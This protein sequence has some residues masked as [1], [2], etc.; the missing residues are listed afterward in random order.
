MPTPEDF[1][2]V[3]RSSY[4]ALIQPKSLSF[5]ELRISKLLA[6]QHVRIVDKQ[7]VGWTAIY[8]PSKQADGSWKIGSCQLLPDEFADLSVQRSVYYSRP[9]ALVL[10]EAKQSPGRGPLDLPREIM[11]SD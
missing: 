1:L 5:R 8:G 7:G 9:T 6:I 4:Q 11:V 3:V 2:R 10:T